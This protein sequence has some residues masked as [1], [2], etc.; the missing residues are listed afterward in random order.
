M[1]WSFDFRRWVLLSSVAAG[2]FHRA[3]NLKNP[4]HIWGGRVSNRS[5]QRTGV[6]IVEVS[7][8]SLSQKGGER[9]REWEFAGRP[10]QQCQNLGEAKEGDDWLII[11][12]PF[13]EASFH[14]VSFIKWRPNQEHS[15]SEAV[16]WRQ[17]VGNRFCLQ[18]PGWLLPI[19]SLGTGFAGAHHQKPLDS[20]QEI[21]RPFPN[22]G[23]TDWAKGILIRCHYWM[24]S[25][26]GEL[27]STVSQRYWLFIQCLASGSG[28]PGWGKLL[29]LQSSSSSPVRGQKNRSDACSTS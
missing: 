6:A 18:W 29:Q 25:R 19:F 24:A 20:S 27:K 13:Q 5:E 10:D 22:K 12:K 16:G 2:N 8:L 1:A 14:Q 21:T 4:L 9:E 11:T 26:T 23:N 17:S 15:I 3:L 28:F 7:L